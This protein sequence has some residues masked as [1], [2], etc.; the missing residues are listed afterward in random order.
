M[1]AIRERFRGYLPVVVDVETGG[2]EASTDGIL[3]LGASILRMDD[4]GRLGI[5]ATHHYHI[6]P[7]EGANIEP[8]ALSFTGIDPWHPFRQAVPEKTALTGLFDIIRRELK[9]QK[10]VRAILVGHNAHFDAGFISAGVER[11]SIKRNPFH[12]FSH[13]DTA[14]LSGLAF[15]QTVLA[16]AC[17]MADIKFDNDEA[18]SALYDAEKTAQLFCEIVNRWQDLGGWQPRSP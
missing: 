5:H 13:F 7:F 2:F 6:E 14:T 12:P 18:H 10:C 15:G 4:S 17:E 9:A 1:S 3:E 16:K 11:C 8:A